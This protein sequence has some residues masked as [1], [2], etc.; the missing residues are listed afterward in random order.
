MDIAA[1]FSAEP[2]FSPQLV[3]LHQL[4]RRHWLGPRGAGQVGGIARVHRVGAVHLFPL[5]RQGSQAAYID[6]PLNHAVIDIP[7]AARG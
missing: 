6:K 7:P 3:Q 4:P 5:L 1:L 2:L